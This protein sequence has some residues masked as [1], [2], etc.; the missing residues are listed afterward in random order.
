M[1]KKN[2]KKDKTAAT[3]NTHTLHTNIHYRPLEVA[4]K[5]ESHLTY[6]NSHR[7]YFL[8]KGV[9]SNFAKF[10]GKHLRPAALLKN[11]CTRCFPVNFAKLLRTSFF[12]KH[13]WAT[14][15]EPSIKVL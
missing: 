14:A 10:T 13:L 12:K 3:K 9:L 11:S 4:V 5:L 1:L 2:M 7:R 15:S 6:R 8:I